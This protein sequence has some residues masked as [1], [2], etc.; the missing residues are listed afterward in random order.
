MN[1]CLLVKWI[2]KIAKG[3]NETWLKL[4]EAKYMPDGNFFNSK[5]K[6]TSQF[7]QGLHK[8]KHL[9]KWGAL[10]KV[11]DGFLIA[12]W[13]DVWLGP[14]PLKTQFPD[15]FNYCE[16]P[17]VLVALAGIMGNGQ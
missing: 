15:L 11:G 17:T 6:G 14:S 8:V 9:F 7:W 5:S 2:W 10:H 13:G 3:G 1:E 16:D 4:L 12:F